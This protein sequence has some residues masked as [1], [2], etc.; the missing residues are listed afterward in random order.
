MAIKSYI[1]ALYFCACLNSGLTCSSLL[2]CKPKVMYMEEE[3]A[4]SIEQVT[5]MLLTKLKETVQNTL[6]KPV[7]Y[8]VVSVSI[9]PSL[10][11][12][13]WGGYIC[14]SARPKSGRFPL[15]H[16]CFPPRCL[17]THSALQALVSYAGC[18]HHLPRHNSRQQGVAGLF[19]VWQYSWSAERRDYRRGVMT[20]LSVTLTKYCQQIVL[21]DSAQILF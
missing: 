2:G 18:V 21:R 15:S 8:C 16:R 6:K 3:K 14:S 7:S 19:C 4:F 9:A 12:R 17:V 20:Y 11:S 10:Q 13:G 5:A 1:S